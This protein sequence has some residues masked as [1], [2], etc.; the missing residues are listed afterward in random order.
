VGKISQNRIIVIIA[1]LFVS[2]GL[3]LLKPEEKSV[4]K[5]YHL[6]DYF[7]KNPVEGW[8]IS[9]QS[10]FEQNLI[11]VLALDDY[12]N[13]YFTNGTDDVSLYIGYYYSAKKIGAAHD[14]L[15]CFPGQ[16]WVLTDKKLK[17]LTLK[18]GEAIDYNV[19]TGTL[20]TAKEL[21][22]YWFQAY[23]KTNQ[24]TFNQKLSIFL[25]RIMGK[26]EDN[27][28]VRITMRVDN[29]NMDHCESVARSFTEN[30]YPVF[31]KYIKQ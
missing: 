6:M 22:L 7:Q 26:G 1:L 4:E 13:L 28:F 10:P 16:G 12:A 20:G 29:K 8:K 5:P 3:A 11:D 21:I 9:S 17:Q 18:N 27:A 2:G 23:D 24:T 19:M 31:L 30:F 15:V 25:K 14:P